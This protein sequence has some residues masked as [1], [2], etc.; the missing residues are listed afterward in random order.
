VTISGFQSYSLSAIKLNMTVTSA[1]PAP[2]PAS[3]AAVDRVS[4]SPD[5]TTAAAGTDATNASAAQASE[6]PAAAPAPSVPPPS[7]AARRADALF[8]ALDGDEDGA[9]TEDEFKEGALNLLRNAAARRRIDDDSDGEGR[10]ARGLRRLERK[11]ER[12]FDR[13]DRN[14]DGAID[15][16]ELTAAL[17]RGRGRRGGPDGPPPPADAPSPQGQAAGAGA[18]SISISVT[19]VSIA[20]QRYTSVQNAEPA[21]TPFPV[22]A[23][24]NKSETPA[25][26]A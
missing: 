2:A 26:A 22:T 17:A 20:V 1:P 9:I 14:D 21:S 11:I 10:E 5:A 18:F 3:A 23:D 12:A 16:D 19:Y 6:L 7:R 24:G 25:L 8:T 4:L 15:K 13:V